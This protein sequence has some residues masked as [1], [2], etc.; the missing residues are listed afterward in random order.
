MNTKKMNIL[1]EYGMLTAA[2][3]AVVIENYFFKFPNH[4]SFGGVTGIAVLLSGALGGSSSTYTFVINIAL[5]ILGF[6]VLGKSFGIKSM[7]VT[8]LMSGSLE[9]IQF[10]CPIEGSV[11]GDPM[12]DWVFAMGIN[13]V[14]AAVIFH[15][16]ASSGGTD[17]IA[18]IIKKYTR[19]K[20]GRALMIVDFA[21][22]VSSFFIYNAAVGCYSLAG[23][24]CKA[25][26]IDSITESL[27]THKCFTIVSTK[28]DEICTFIQKVL[29]HSAT[30]YN[31]EGS[32]SHDRKTVIL[33]V[34]NRNQALLLRDYVNSVDEHAFMVISNSSEIIGKGFSEMD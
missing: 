32:Y 34:V 23:Y 28:A 11:T 26:F 33:S 31:A 10:L 9:V 15:L 13:A 7:Y 6:L 12:L 25:L 20:I 3:L 27:S 2:T 16:G 19:I 5:F 8:L 24:L 30:T 1:Q 4:F 18:M 29:K 17:I 14:T 21:V 22:V